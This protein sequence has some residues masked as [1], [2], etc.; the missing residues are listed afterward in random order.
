MARQGTASP[1]NAAGGAP[2]DPASAASPRRAAR[3][4]VATINPV[5]GPAW[6]TRRADGPTAAHRPGPARQ[7]AAYGTRVAVRVD[8]GGRRSRTNTRT[9]PRPH[10]RTPRSTEPQ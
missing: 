7:G 8:L 6:R 9:T 1:R 10:H 2:G 5:P 4:A 3:P